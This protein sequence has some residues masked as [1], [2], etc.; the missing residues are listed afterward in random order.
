[1][2]GGGPGW[3]WLSES[4]TSGLTCPSQGARNAPLPGG[5]GRQTPGAVGLGG[6]KTTDAE[7][8]VADAKADEPVGRL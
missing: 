4:R 2:A 7:S 5:V 8:A 3:N 1:M 6:L